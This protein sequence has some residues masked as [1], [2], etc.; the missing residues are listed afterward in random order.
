MCIRDS[1]G[2]AFPKEIPVGVV[3]DSWLSKDGLYIEARVKLNADL[4][5]LEEVRV[6]TEY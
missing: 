2:G 6:L 5:K 3:E 4:N 1:L